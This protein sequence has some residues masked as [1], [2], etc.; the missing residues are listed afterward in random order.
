MEK[1]RPRKGL[2]EECRKWES[3]RRLSGKKQMLGRCEKKGMTVKERDDDAKKT[4]Q[5]KRLL[6]DS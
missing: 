4:Q 6:T 1:R 3:D 5:N 2:S